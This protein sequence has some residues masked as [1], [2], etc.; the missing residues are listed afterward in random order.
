M[1][2]YYSLED[3]HRKKRSVHALLEGDFGV[4][5]WAWLKHMSIILLSNKKIILPISLKGFLPDFLI[6]PLLDLPP[7][8]QRTM[9][10]L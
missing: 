4:D 2:Y 6:I 5:A 7:F 1:L 10:Y 8:L 3:E 9:N